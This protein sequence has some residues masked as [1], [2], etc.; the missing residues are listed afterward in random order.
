MGCGEETFEG[1]DS[2]KSSLIPALVSDAE[3]PDIS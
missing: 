1:G 2:K 3:L